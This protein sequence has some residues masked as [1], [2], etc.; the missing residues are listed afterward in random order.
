MQ[1]SGN[2]RVHPTQ[3]NLWYDFTE[4][5]RSHGRPLRVDEPLRAPEYASR[6]VLKLKIC[7]A[8]PVTL[9]VMRPIERFLR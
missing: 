2:A 5:R 4:R 7:L 6:F 3:F 8:Y 1:D 9:D